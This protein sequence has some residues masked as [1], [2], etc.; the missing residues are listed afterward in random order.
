LTQL[1]RTETVSGRISH[2]E[3]DSAASPAPLLILQESTAAAVKQGYEIPVE[4]TLFIN[5]WA[6]GRHP[7]AWGKTAGE[8]CRSGSWAAAA[9]QVWT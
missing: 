4:S 7:A 2:S 9:G 6:V 1:N 5:R 8:F 3:R